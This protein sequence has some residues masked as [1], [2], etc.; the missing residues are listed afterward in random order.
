[1]SLIVL[2]RSC[3]LAQ[4]WTLSFSHPL[5]G[6]SVLFILGC[7]FYLLLLAR[8]A[9]SERGGV[10]PS[11]CRPNLSRRCLPRYVS[12]IYLLCFG[13]R[14]RKRQT[15]ISLKSLPVWLRR[16]AAGVPSSHLSLGLSVFFLFCVSP[17]YQS[18]ILGAWIS[19]PHPSFGVCVLLT[20]VS[21]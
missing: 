10:C 5:F 14:D 7:P 6:V 15:P 17:S 20:S 8:A 9:P 16:A 18:S 12:S 4:V 1:M 11:G 19:H 3:S 21:L 2:P 13:K